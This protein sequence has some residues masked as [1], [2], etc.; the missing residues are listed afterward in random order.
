MTTGKLK[1]SLPVIGVLVG[2]CM[3]GTLLANT[4]EDQVWFVFSDTETPPGVGAAWEPVQVPD[5][6]NVTH[7]DRGGNAWYRIRRHLDEPPSGMWAVLLEKINMNAAVFIGD[8]YLGD[9]GSFDEPI[10][11]NWISPLLFKVPPGLLQGGDND[12]YIRIAAYPNDGGGLHIYHIGPENILKKRYRVVYAFYI[13]S[14]QIAFYVQIVFSML[15]LLLWWYRKRDMKYFWLSAAGWAGSVFSVNMFIY[16]TF[17]PRDIWEAILQASIGWFIWFLLMFSHRFLGIRIPWL[18][19]S[20]SVYALG[21]ASILFLV[22]SSAVVDSA[23][24]WQSVLIVV[25]IYIFVMAIIQ[26][27]QKRD[28]DRLVWMIIYGGMLAVGVRDWLVYTLMGLS[29][30]SVTF[31][32]GTSG[33]VLLT[34]M[35]L[36]RRFVQALN[37]VERLNTELQGKIGRIEAEEM[38]QQAVSD[39]RSRIVRDLHDG[40]GNSLVSAMALSLDTRSSSPELQATLQDAMAE[41]RLI[42][43]SATGAGFNTNKA[44]MLVKERAESVMSAANI[45][46][47]WDMQA[48]STHPLAD[49]VAGMHMVRI[50]QEAITNAIKHARATEITVRA[51]ARDRHVRVEVSDNG[52][53]ISNADANHGNGLENM[54]TRAGE[55]NA[56][57]EIVSDSPGTRIILTLPV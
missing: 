41:M 37:D 4:A 3:P 32:F 23:A 42:V 15:L 9:G 18:E 47:K 20:V 12:I 19:R 13:V 46:L 49:E 51:E 39:E 30:Y 45:A 26:W 53:G 56:M 55:I 48:L 57:L 54:R 27:W 11:R 17:V 40:L 10:T 7:P 38:K 24:A 1:F 16:D 2:L 29:E 34:S 6:W 28:T 50:V 52:I 8:H 36:M 25:S 31:H 22:P 21:G 14:S 33:L 44:L 35:I 5:N 43:D